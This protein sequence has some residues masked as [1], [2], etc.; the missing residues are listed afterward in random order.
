MSKLS[1]ADA[2]SVIAL[3]ERLEWLSLDPT[4]SFTPIDSLP[5]DLQ[6][7]LRLLPEWTSF[8]KREYDDDL[9]EWT[10]CRLGVGAH[11]VLD[12]IRAAR[13]AECDRLQNDSIP[14]TNVV[15]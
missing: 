2:L 13:K 9:G 15:S 6:S 7:A 10:H 5:K 1:Y 11:F 14:K 8:L 12:L 4:R 3:L